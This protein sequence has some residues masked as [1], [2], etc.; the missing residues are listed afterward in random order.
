M[1]LRK[2]K[3][4]DAP[5]MFEWMHDDSV[6]HNLYTDF[7]SKTIEDCMQFIESSWKSDD[8]L[9]LAIVS[10]S[11]EYMGTVSLKYINR[12]SKDAEFAITV[13]KIAMGKGY[14]QYAMTE[15]IRIAFDQLKL[16]TVYWC[17]SKKN[18]RAMRFYEKM[19]YKDAVV[20]PERILKRYV[21]VGS[22]RWFQ[23][24]K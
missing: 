10:D 19:G 12:V 7:A 9:N 2:L 17:V 11:D 23:I 20:L 24:S 6:V 5:L 16:N 15:I 13:R 1:Q 21:C 14:S 18:L 8:A 4:E 3:I 22:L